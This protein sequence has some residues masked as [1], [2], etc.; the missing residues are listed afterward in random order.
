MER[1]NVKQNEV[2]MNSWQMVTFQ[3]GLSEPY[4]LLYEGNIKNQEKQ[5]KGFTN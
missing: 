3:S 2:K 4:S 5:I 1:R